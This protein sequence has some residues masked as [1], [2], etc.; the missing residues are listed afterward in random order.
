MESS[1]TRK[2]LELGPDLRP[3]YL[4]SRQHRL[5]Y[6]AVATSP[7]GDELRLK[8]LMATL[9]L[10]EGLSFFI[11]D[12]RL[13]LERVLLFVLSIAAISRLSRR[14][15]TQGSICVPSDIMAPAAGAWMMLAATVTGGFMGLKGA[16]IEAIEFTGAYYAFRYLLGPVDSSVR[17]V[18]FSCKLIILVVG[19]ALLDPLTSKLFTYEFIKGITGY[20]KPAYESALAAQAEALYRDGLIRAMG[21]LEHSILFGAVCVWFGTLAFFMFPSRLFGWSVAGIALIG[22][23]FSEAR[24]P[25][26]SYLIAFALTIFYSATPRFTARWKLIGLFVTIGLVA[27]FS[28]SGSPV[29]TL[30]RLSG[31]SAESG[32]YR[33]AIWDTAVPLVVESPLF[34]I[35]LSDDWNWQANGGLVS[36]SVD[37]FWLKAAMV[38]GIPGSILIL[39]TLVSAFW[40]G[41][42]DRSPHLT[43]EEKRLSVALGIVVTTAVFLG[44]IV[45]FWGACGIL[46]AA[47]AG[48][49]AN[50]AE[51]AMLRDGEAAMIGIS[52]ATR[53]NKV[54]KVSM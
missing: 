17:V 12:F 52:P 34:G 11:G 53:E 48:M 10:P 20:T 47:F 46:L 7:F 25:L 2:S 33:Q 50:L 44:F 31:V 36:A 16:G 5:T 26:L 32:W 19:V 3:T 28:F 42:I 1:L 51:S 8:L 4:G 38:Y 18:R 13:S 30:V 27:V 21:P 14:T 45:H 43:P 37:A 54:M 6:R 23:W 35:G 24:G 15:N 22:V 49:R 9:F 41:P 29:A 40:L 39:L